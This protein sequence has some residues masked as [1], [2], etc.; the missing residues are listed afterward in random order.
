MVHS[1]SEKQVSS[2]VAGIP[3]VSIV[4]P[5]YNAE[6]FV[7]QAIQSALDQN[8]P[9]KEVIVID[10]GSTDAS[11][12]IIKS[13]GDA[14][15]WESGPNR[16]GCAARNR[17]LKLARGE[18]VQFHDADDLLHPEK[19]A[20]QV[21]VAVEDPTRIVYCGYD[22]IDE[23]GNSISDVVRRV[24]S[25]HREDP[26]VFVLLQA[27]LTTPAPLHWKNRLTAIGGF[28]E[29]LACAQERDLHL[30]LACNGASL[31]HLAKNL[32]K[33]RR[34]RGSVSSNFMRLTDQYTD[35]V[36]RAYEEL[37]ANGGLTE[38]RRAA[39]AGLLAMCARNYLDSGQ[40]EDS[41]DHFAQA[42]RLHRRG[43]IPQAYNIPTRILY[44]ILGPETTQL[45]VNWKRRHLF[46][47]R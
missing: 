10:D 9:H 7:G 3:Y 25:Y 45:I 4:I 6:R 8:Y 42:R 34:V 16:G 26:V 36:W 43:G 5:C 33:I 17:G 30:R 39:M 32:V 31:L 37:R 38:P 22:F 1:L 13:F 24:P 27:G 18:L 19:L 21:P 44:R 35:I 15:R 41:R 14:L 28:R 20:L 23:E 2:G 40:I 46:A 29:G 11:L 47:G 12:E